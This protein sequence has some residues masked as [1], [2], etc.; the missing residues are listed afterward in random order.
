MCTGDFRL[1]AILFIEQSQQTKEQVMLKFRV[2][3]RFAKRRVSKILSALREVYAVISETDPLLFHYLWIEA[4]VQN[5]MTLAIFV[6]T[7]AIIG[8]MQS[9]STTNGV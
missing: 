7:G 9:G 4:V 1:G 3:L 8:S 2:L 5:L 6:G